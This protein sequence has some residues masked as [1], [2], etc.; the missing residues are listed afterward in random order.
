MEIEIMLMHV[1]NGHHS[2]AGE[3]N[4]LGRRL[5]EKDE[6][7]GFCRFYTV[8]GCFIHED[9]FLQRFILAE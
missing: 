6:W 1:V 3:N 7:E 5:V 9:K 4:N 8:F 2:A